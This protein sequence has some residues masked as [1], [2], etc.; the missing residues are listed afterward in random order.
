MASRSGRTKS[1]RTESATGTRSGQPDVQPLTHR[2]DQVEACTHLNFSLNLYSVMLQKHPCV[3]SVM[4]VNIF[5][6]C[7]HCKGC[8]HIQFSHQYIIA[9]YS[10]HRII[11]GVDTCTDNIRSKWLGHVSGRH[12]STYWCRMVKRR[13]DDRC[14]HDPISRSPQT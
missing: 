10:C 1:S 2:C 6:D 7:V 4:I 14:I 9:I 12:T 8:E 5:M 13:L 3:H 11:T